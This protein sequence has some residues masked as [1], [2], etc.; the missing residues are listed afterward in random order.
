M[1]VKASISMI[2]WVGFDDFL[3]PH[4]RTVATVTP[5]RLVTSFTVSTASMGF[6]RIAYP[7]HA[8]KG[9]GIK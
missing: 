5:R 1:L 4:L 3:F 2:I 8:G 9:L 7:Y 6:K